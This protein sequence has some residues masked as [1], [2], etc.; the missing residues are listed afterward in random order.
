LTRD[1]E[2]I[3]RI[4][5]RGRPPVAG[6]AFSCR[7]EDVVCDVAAVAQSLAAFL[8][9]PWDTAMAAPHTSS[10]VA[11]T[12]S[13]EQV[14]TRQEKEERGAPFWGPTPAPSHTHT[15]PWGNVSEFRLGRRAHKCARACLG[16]NGHRRFKKRAGTPL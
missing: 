11:H 9:L 10:R 1:K 14:T 16:S 3:Q 12:S 8:E 4:S 7:Y 2:G 15:Q 13:N 5:G 6:L